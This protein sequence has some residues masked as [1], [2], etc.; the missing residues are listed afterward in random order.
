MKRLIY[1]A[2]VENFNSGLST[3][4]IPMTP[5]HEQWSNETL[6]NAAASSGSHYQF[7]W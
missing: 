5:L 4:E 1:H 3:Q 7:A 2:L 6:H